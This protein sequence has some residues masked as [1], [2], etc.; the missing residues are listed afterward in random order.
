MIFGVARYSGDTALTVLVLI[1]YSIISADNG[2]FCR[3]LM[4]PRLED[5][6]SQHLM[7]CVDRVSAVY[8]FRC[9]KTLTLDANT[10]DLTAFLPFI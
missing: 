2:V 4:D 7:A 1:I 8:R 3:P 6:S 9:V 5:H 10:C